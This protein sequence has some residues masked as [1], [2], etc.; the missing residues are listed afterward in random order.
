MRSMLIVPRNSS[1]AQSEFSLPV[2]GVR[3]YGWR[4]GNLAFCLEEGCHSCVRGS[5]VRRSRHDTVWPVDAEY[6]ATPDAQKGAGER[7]RS[8]STNESH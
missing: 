1:T 6:V 2:R 4:G 7:W 5:G 3:E 8:A